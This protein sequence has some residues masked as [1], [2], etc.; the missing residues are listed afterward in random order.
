MAAYVKTVLIAGAGVMGS[1]IAQA[2]ATAGIHVR[3]VDTHATALPRAR[4]LIESGLETMVEA[5]KVAGADVATIL[6][7]VDLSTDLH[8]AL[9]A[10]DFV[11]E[12]VSEDADIKGR[13]LAE[14]NSQ[15]H[16]GVVVASNT[17]SLDVFG[18]ADFKHPECL[19]IAHFFAPGHI[20][21]LV[22]VVPGPQ[23]SPAAVALT[24][25]LMVRIGKRPVVL[26]RF[27]PSFIVNRI[28]QAIGQAVEEILENG[29]AGPEEIDRAVKLSLG[30]RLP[31]VGV[32]QTIDF[33]GLDVVRDILRSIGR[34]TSFFDE[35]V[36][37]GELGVKTGRGMYDYGGRSEA[38][39]LRKRDLLYL[40]MV[41]VLDEF[42]VFDAV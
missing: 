35:R 12:A 3:L 41:D 17:S 1:S 28:Q 7:R 34:D 38:E 40:K 24:A 16:A 37:A 9:T 10:A 8:S 23:T 2:F 19:V 6:D 18:L 25:A 20:I 15:C 32:V 33:T 29:W 11:L 26:E 21:P 4:G 13:V 42:G 36:A 14:L 5:G 22:E 27:V 31:V 39:V 30:V